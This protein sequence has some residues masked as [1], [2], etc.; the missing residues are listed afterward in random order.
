MKE[1]LAVVLMGVS[2]CGK[3]SVGTGLSEMLGWPFYDGDDYHPQ[4][5]IDRM[6]AGIPLTDEDRLPWLEGLRDLILRD[7]SEGCSLIVACSALKADYRKILDGGR[8]DVHFVFLEGS[9]ELIQ[10]RLQARSG[11]YMKPG[12]LRSQFATLELPEEAQTVS[13]DQP[14][15][16]IVEAIVAAI[17]DQE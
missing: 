14:V 9:F 15:G 2:G 3:T 17:A 1:P 6:S 16:K 12:M 13:I 7:L 4:A 10:K 8:G 5:N 11:H